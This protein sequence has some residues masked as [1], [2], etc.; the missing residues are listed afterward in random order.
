MMVRM[1]LDNSVVEVSPGGPAW[2]LGHHSKL[3]FWY[4]YMIAGADMRL[5]QGFEINFCTCLMSAFRT[6]FIWRNEKSLSCLV[7]K[8]TQSDGTS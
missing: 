4:R 6:A 7:L 3:P 8:A 5:S 2:T 1:G